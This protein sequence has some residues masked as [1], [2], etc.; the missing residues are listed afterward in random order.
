MRKLWLGLISF[1]ILQNTFAEILI[2]SETQRVDK[3]EAVGRLIKTGER[4]VALLGAI[5]VKRTKEQFLDYYR[6]LEN[7]KNSPIVIEVGKFHNP[8]RPEDVANMTLD[9]AELKDIRSCRPGKCS[10]KLNTQEMDR[11]QTA[12]NWDGP[13]IEGQANRLA[14]ELILKFVTGYMAKGS[15]ALG[16]LNDKETPLPLVNVFT[17][18]LKNF[19]YLSNRYP[20]LFTK[21]DVSSQTEEF[22]YWSREK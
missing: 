21:I 22:I 20:H 18:L 1:F 17:A 2:P 19:P 5:R 4:D 6:N 16:T 12:M 11:Y 14:R 8:P 13:D 10:S 9:A 7:M 15:A 3:G